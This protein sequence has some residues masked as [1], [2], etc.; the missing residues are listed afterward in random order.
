MVRHL[1]TLF[2]E[3]QLIRAHTVVHPG[4]NQ[5]F[6]IQIDP[7]FE[8]L[9]GFMSIDALRSKFNRLKRAGRVPHDANAEANMEP[10]LVEENDFPGDVEQYLDFENDF[11]VDEDVHGGND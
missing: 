1:W 6:S 2:E 3:E 5:W 10:V 11:W 9:F 7:E 4:R 8:G